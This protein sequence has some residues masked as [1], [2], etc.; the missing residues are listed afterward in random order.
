MRGGVFI[1][2]TEFKRARQSLPGFPGRVSVFGSEESGLLFLGLLGRLK[3][4]IAKYRR[5]RQAEVD[6]AFFACQF[7]QIG[8]AP[9]SQRNP[10]PVAREGD[11]ISE[12]ETR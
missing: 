3:S 8:P 11:A 4:W 5:C 2:F 10:H 9:P 1:K 12:R 7:R 6:L